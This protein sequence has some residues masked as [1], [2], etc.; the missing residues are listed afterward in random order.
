MGGQR[1]QQGHV[2]AAERAHR[3]VGGVEHTQDLLA[4]DQG[5]A[6]DR[7]EVLLGDRAVDLAGVPE[8]LVVEVVGGGVRRGRLRHE[9]TEP[10]SHRQP[11]LAEGL[12]DDPLGDP[13]VGVAALGIVHAQVGHVGVQQLPGPA[14]DRLQHRVQVGEPGQVAGGL[15]Q[16]G[17]LVLAPQ[18]RHE[19]VTDLQ[20]Q[21]LRALQ[22][23]ED[24]LGLA[25]GSRGQDRRLVLHGGGV[26]REQLEVV[27]PH[28][29]D[30]PVPWRTGIASGGVGSAQCAV[31]PPSSTSEAPVTASA[32]GV[33]R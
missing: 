1:D 20:R 2:L 9:P 22:L 10:G 26:T 13:H 14:H 15:V 24:V 33:H 27:G 16:G 7:G 28:G 32:A 29:A 31:Q 6:E 4:E 8:A 23:G 12:G 11:H 18:P 21:R 5:D 3:A 25:A 17:Q 30:C 19:R